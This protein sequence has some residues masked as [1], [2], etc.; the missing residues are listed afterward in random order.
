M[1]Q[2]FKCQPSHLQYG[3]KMHFLRHGNHRLHF[4]FNPI[5]TVTYTVRA[6]H[7]IR[8]KLQASVC[9]CLQNHKSSEA[10]FSEYA[11]SHL[12][13]CRTKAQPISPRSFLRHTPRPMHLLKTLSRIGHS[14]SIVWLLLPHPGKTRYF[15]LDEHTALS[16]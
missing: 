6:K 3:A 11:L 14:P 12:Y 4:Q 16:S 2:L 5:S 10:T 15:L 7:A 8:H 9:M 1:L 13:T